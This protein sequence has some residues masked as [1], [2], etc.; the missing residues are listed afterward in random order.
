MIY[1]TNLE[2]AIEMTRA[3]RANKENIL[4]PNYRHQDILPICETFSRD[5]F[6]GLLNLPGSRKIRIYYGMDKYSKIRLIPVAVN[7]NDEDILEIPAKG[8]RSSSAESLIKKVKK[9]TGG[10]KKNNDASSAGLREGRS[11]PERAD[12]LQSKTF[13][14][15]STAPP[16]MSPM[17]SN[18]AKTPFGKN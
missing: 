13:I 17:N 4:E 16:P 1:F 11:M 12:A 9:K 3:F 15:S 6:D 2:E 7:A 18:E 5:A 10:S 8:K 14:E